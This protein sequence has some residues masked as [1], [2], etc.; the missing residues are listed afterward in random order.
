LFGNSSD[1]YFNVSKNPKYSRVQVVSEL[2]LMAGLVGRRKSSM[3]QMIRFMQVLGDVSVD[4]EEGQF[5]TCA[6]LSK[7]SKVLDC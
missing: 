5:I 4:L 2:I 1:D 6:N 7:V 3:F